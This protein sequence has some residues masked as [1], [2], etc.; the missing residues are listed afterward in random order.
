MTF[1]IQSASVP[2]VPANSFALRSPR[3]V[4]GCFR[5]T[6]VNR[7]SNILEREPSSPLWDRP[8][9]GGAGAEKRR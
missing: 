5:K 2:V 7:K 1:T 3:I 6:S 9:N 8:N 4:E